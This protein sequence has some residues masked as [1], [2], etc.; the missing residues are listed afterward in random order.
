MTDGDHP[1]EIE[2]RYLAIKD[3]VWRAAEA[4]RARAG[5]A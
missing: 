2:E 4:A 5:G 1:R 3:R